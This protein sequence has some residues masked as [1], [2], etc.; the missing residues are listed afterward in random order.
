MAHEGKGSQELFRLSVRGLPGGEAADDAPSH[1]SNEE[2]GSEEL[3]ALVVVLAC[4]AHL[5]SI[6]VA[7]RVPLQL[8]KKQDGLRMAA[9]RDLGR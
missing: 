7:C 5:A 3:Q 6:A 9:A 8:S 2:R 4:M 1:A